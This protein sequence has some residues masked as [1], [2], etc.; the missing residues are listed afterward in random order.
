[1]FSPAS[2]F[3]DENLL[4]GDSVQNL[5]KEDVSD[6]SCDSF[7]C[8][9]ECDTVS[10]L[11]GVDRG[12][13]WDC[14]AE[15]DEAGKKSK[16]GDTAVAAVKYLEAHRPSTFFFENIKNL[17]CAGRSGQSN[18]QWLVKQANRLGYHVV[19]MLLDSLNFGIPQQRERFYLLGIFTGEYTDQQAENARVPDW[20]LDLKQFVRTMA[21]PPFELHEFLCEPSDPEV[22]AVNEALEVIP[23]KAKK[24]GGKKKAKKAAEGQE[25]MQDAEVDAKGGNVLVYHV[26]HLDAY[27]QHGLKWPLTLPDEFMAKVA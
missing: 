25:E 24:K 3:P 8:G 2:I 20:A 27:G 1:M 17:A 12:E 11:N 21:I 14:A 19:Y 4:S 13:N 6:L 9:V 16:T 18:L 22:I 7:G 23:K 10:G 5:L 15:A 26:E